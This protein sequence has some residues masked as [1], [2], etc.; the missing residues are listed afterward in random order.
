MP[1]T[2]INAFTLGALVCN[3]LL[4]MITVF[5]AP[6]RAEIVT[7]TYEIYADDFRDSNGNPPNP[8]T[9]TS[10]SGTVTFAF[11]TNETNNINLVPLAVTGIDITR[12]DGVT[13][14]YNEINTAVNAK[15]VSGLWRITVG[16]LLNGADSMAGISDDFRVVFDTNLADF[17]FIGIND[18]FRFNTEIDF[19][20]SYRAHNTIVQLQDNEV[21]PDSYT[22]FR[23]IYVSGALDD[24]FVSD[25]ND[26]C[27]Q[28]G[29]TLMASE[30]PITLDF[31]GTIPDGIPADLNARI[32]S[33]ANSIGLTMTVSF[34]NWNTGQFDP[35]GSIGE[36]FSADSVEIF[37]GVVADHIH[38]LNQTV[39]TRVQWRAEGLVVLYPWTV[40]IDQ[41]VWEVQ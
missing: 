6:A 20:P 25:D 1:D 16:G 35:V 31:E 12:N 40:C 2:S 14:D 7:L 27:Y 23:G 24:V 32:E 38:Q 8:P 26:L 37:A 29:L 5:A 41:V 22:E 21:L 9:S 17:E 33:S 4:F 15:L 11:D 34:F 36:T 13:I 19:E 10:I 18:D 28:P 39:K 3:T 30:A